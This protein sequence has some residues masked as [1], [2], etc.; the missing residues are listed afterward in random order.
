MTI[1]R[2]PHL[3]MPYLHLRQKA[4][5]RVRLF[6]F[7]YAGGSASAFYSWLS[8]FPS[9]I[10]VCPIQLPGRENRF[11]EPPLTSLKELLPLLAS[12]LLPYLDREFAFFGHSMGALICF[13]LARYLRREHHLCPI[14]LFASACLAPQQLHLSPSFHQLPETAFIDQVRQCYNGIPHELQANAE[15]M[16]V[17]LPILRADFTLVEMYTYKI[18]NPLDCPI[19]VLGGLQ[20]SSTQRDELKVWA[21][22]TH[23][24]CTLHMLP[25][26]HFF[27]RSAQSLLVQ[28]VVQDL[29]K[30]LE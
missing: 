4:K 26:D 28:T 10:E 13:E 25:G 16:A 22:H 17:Y 5:V 15:L 12:I 2:A 19:T 7:S 8:M 23:N 11:S 24:N 3:W 1:S 29:K 27:L 20:D 9:E 30:Y 14:H 6:C 21:A 18:E